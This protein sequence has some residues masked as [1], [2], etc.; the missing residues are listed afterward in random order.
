MTAGVGHGRA[1]EDANFSCGA[2]AAAPGAALGR[3]SRT[4]AASSRRW[5]GHGECAVEETVS[6]RRWFGWRRCGYVSPTGP[7]RL[8]LFGAVVHHVQAE[9]R[10]WQTT[11]G[12]GRRRPRRGDWERAAKMHPHWA[13]ALRQRTPSPIASKSV[14][15]VLSHHAP[16]T[17]PGDQPGC[18][19][20]VLR[21]MSLTY[22]RRQGSAGNASIGDRPL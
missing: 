19:T 5:L 7:R 1:R 20:N 16:G 13:A 17:G 14:C 8:L 4:A 15:E 18:P 6:G 12:R 22:C 10:R 11:S 9:I 21:G 2:G 3:R